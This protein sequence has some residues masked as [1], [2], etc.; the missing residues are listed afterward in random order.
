[1]LLTFILSLCPLEEDGNIEIYP[2]RIPYVNFA[3]LPWTLEVP[4][5]IAF[6]GSFSS[7]ACLRVCV[8]ERKTHLAQCLACEQCQNMVA[9]LPPSHASHSEASERREMPSTPPKTSVQRG[10]ARHTHLC[11]GGDLYQVLATEAERRRNVVWPGA[12]MKCW[13]RKCH[14]SCVS[15]GSWAKGERH[16]VAHSAQA[17]WVW[18]R[19]LGGDRVGTR[20]LLDWKAEGKN[21][22]FI[23]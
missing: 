5:G 20:L 16:Q 13:H 9:T 14:L 11:F 21:L 18:G 7:V 8:R 4:I 22:D 15:E 6:E 3:S 1:M 19:G 12:S 23:L 17:G 10:R 2:S